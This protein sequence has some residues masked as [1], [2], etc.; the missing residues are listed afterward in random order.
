V[1]QLPTN[2]EAEGDVGLLALTVDVA[3]DVASNTYE[4]LRDSL[5]S[6]IEATKQAVTHVNEQLSTLDA[7]RPHATTV[8]TPAWQLS[9]WI[10]ARTPPR[11]R[12]CGRRCPKSRARSLA[13]NISKPIFWRTV[14]TMRMGQ[15]SVDSLRLAPET[16]CAQLEKNSRTIN[17]RELIRLGQRDSYGRLSRRDPQRRVVRHFNCIAL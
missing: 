4:I 17:T 7:I 8:L 15:C 12:T 5:E 13:A 11:P 16:F 6:P 2:K 9:G 3:R 10:A 14:C 1:V